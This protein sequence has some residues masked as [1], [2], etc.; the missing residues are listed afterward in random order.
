LLFGALLSGGQLL[1]AFFSALLGS[2]QLFD[3]QA[4]GLELLFGALLGSS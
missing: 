1:N 3:A 2:S 4:K